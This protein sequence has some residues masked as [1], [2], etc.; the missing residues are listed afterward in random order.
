M[1]HLEVSN[2]PQINGEVKVMRLCWNKKLTLCT[3]SFI[4]LKQHESSVSNCL[5]P[6]AGNF[7]VLICQYAYTE[8]CS[9]TM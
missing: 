6:K 1:R 7:E 2:T 8:N 4:T 9:L 5:H 3:A